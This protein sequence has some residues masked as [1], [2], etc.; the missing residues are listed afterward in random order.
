MDEAGVDRQVLTA[1]PQM[2]YFQNERDAVS[3]AQLANDRYAELVD[4]YPNRFTALAATPLPHGEAAAAEVERAMDELGMPGAN[5]STTVLDS[6]LK[7][8]RFDP[9]WEALDQREGIVYVHAAGEGCRSPLIT[10]HGL[11]WIVGAPFEDTVGV[12]HLLQAGVPVRYPNIKFV[13]AHLGGPLPFYMQRIDDNY[14]H[15]DAAFPDTPSKLLKNMWFDTANF[16]E[17]ALICAVESLGVDQ[18][19][20]GSDY[21]YFQDE[22]YTRAVTY[23]ENARLSADNVERIL[24][25]N[26]ASLL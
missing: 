11:R 8:S 25:T 12:L 10:E 24:S 23:V 3:L 17:P 16:H 14:E 7:D 5:V 15:W 26:A 6:T 1:T 20:L 21:P 4:Q 9:M 2:P 13:I 22:L 18:I 19:L